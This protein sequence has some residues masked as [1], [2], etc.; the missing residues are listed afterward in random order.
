MDFTE[1]VTVEQAEAQTPGD[2]AA[3]S[4]VKEDGTLVIDILVRE[5]CGAGHTGDIVVCAPDPAEHRPEG[6]VPPPAQPGFRPEVQLAP[7]AKAGVRVETDPWT[8]SERVMV[9]VTLAF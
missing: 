9:D 1:P 6:A 3:Q 7:N 5:P 8:Q 4:Y 2:A